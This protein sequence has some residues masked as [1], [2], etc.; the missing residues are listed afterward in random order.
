MQNEIIL[1]QDDSGN[2]RIDV[3]M[4]NET[5]WLTQKQ[6]SE[7]FQTTTQNITLHLKNVYQEGELDEFSTCKD[8]LQVRQEGKREVKRKQ[9]IYNLDAIISVG[10]RI[11]SS[12]ATQFRIWATKRLKDYLLQGYA[13]NEKRLQENKQQFLK[14]LD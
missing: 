9:K 7:L 13:I 8:F 12:V 2:V 1:Y 10:Y 14:A 5:I 4:E 6:M 11:K 3:R